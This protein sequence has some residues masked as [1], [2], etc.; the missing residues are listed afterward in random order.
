M[1][2]YKLIMAACLLALVNVLTGC[3]VE[4]PI[5]GPQGPPGF[6][7]FQG[8]QGPPGQDGASGTGL[9]YFVEKFALNAD[10]DWQIF[11]R[12]PEQDVILESDAILVYLLWDQVESEDGSELVDVWRAMPVNYFYDAGLLQINYDF[13]TGDVRI[14]AEAAFPL[15]AE[16]DVYENLEARIVV[17][18]ADYLANAR[19]SELVDLDNYEAVRKWLN[20]PVR[21]TENATPFLNAVP[22]Q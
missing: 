6:D 21:A 22:K 7:G 5:P 12:F 3:Y 16:Q 17:V 19:T 13:S 11:Y 9:A 20:L 4:E 1:Q 15:D 2:S 14:F 8:P 18:P 10:N